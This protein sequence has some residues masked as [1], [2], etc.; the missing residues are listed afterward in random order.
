MEVY[1][2]AVGI[3]A[4]GLVGWA[5]AAPVLA[6]ARSYHP[7]PLPRYSPTMLPA[8]ERRRT[9]ATI[10][11]A[12]QAAAEAMSSEPVSAPGAV[13]ASSDGDLDIVD[14]LCS[15]LALPERSVSP[16]HFH[17][18][19]HNAPA[20]YWSIGSGI[21]APSTSLS[22]GDGSFAA[23]LLE[24]A[25]LTLAEARPTLLVAYDHPAPAPL[26]RIR[27]MSAPFAAALVLTPNRPNG[28][29]ARL[30]MALG[31]S[32]ETTLADGLEQLR[33]GNPA[34]RALPLLGAIAR[35]EAAGVTLPYLDGT[36]LE[37]RC[38]PC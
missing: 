33:R 19:V 31:R 34:A 30:W 22:A 21:T 14:R 37:V 9:T 26:D 1:L 8:N 7:E 2:C 3:V 10:K 29:L 4:P 11:L 13:F 18:S 28:A 27:P 25:T 38:E 36:A 23:G 5:Q 20:G 6:G 16:T 12:L 17:N 32:E 35:G 24:A 15:A